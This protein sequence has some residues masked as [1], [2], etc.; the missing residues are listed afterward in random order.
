MSRR[1]GAYSKDRSGHGLSCSQRRLVRAMSNSTVPASARTVEPRRRPT[2]AHTEGSPFPLGVTWIETEQA[3]NFAVHSEHA[4]S[5]TLLLYSATDLVN[6]L[7][8]F[9]FDYLRNKSGQ[10]WHCRMPISEIGEARY[11]AY[12]V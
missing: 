5:V 4:E 9:R 8:T 12:S 10:I 11:Y 1:A 3:F 7:F 2:W 6:P